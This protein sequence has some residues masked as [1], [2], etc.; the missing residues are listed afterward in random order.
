M[1]ALEKSTA[2]SGAVGILVTPGA[3]S[4]EWLSRARA[5]QDASTYSSVH[6]SLSVDE[7]MTM[8]VDEWL[9]ILAATPDATPEFRANQ[10]RDLSRLF[11][12]S[13]EIGAACRV[14][15]LGDGT[16]KTSTIDDAFLRT[17]LAL[18]T[19]STATNEAL[20]LFGDQGPLTPIAFDLLRLNEKRLVVHEPF[21][22]FDLTGRPDVLAW[23]PHMT[24]PEGQWRLAIAFE[25]DKAAAA[26]SLAFEW[27]SLDSHE[28]H[29][30]SLGRAGRYDI[31]LDGHW[32]TTAIAEFRLSAAHAVFSGNI[33]L[34]SV[35]LGRA[36]IASLHA[37]LSQL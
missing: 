31:A 3:N 25:V 27:G 20:R 16:E 32:N 28:R 21:A 11:S 17:D 30:V 13:V 14:L 9:V 26:Q 10:T 7:A 37:A 24:L 5:F 34:I 29:E 15:G 35:A 23:G 4:D 1:T 6:I 33:R 19:S 12:R 18:H 22:T 36:P 8:R 2:S